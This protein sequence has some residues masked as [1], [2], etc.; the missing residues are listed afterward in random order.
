MCK[1]KDCAFYN[2]VKDKIEE[3]EQPITGE[4]YNS[5]IVL[6]R[7]GEVI[8]EIPNPQGDYLILDAFNNTL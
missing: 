5:N 7:N 4:V 3:L 1:D 6:T 8:G 2:Y